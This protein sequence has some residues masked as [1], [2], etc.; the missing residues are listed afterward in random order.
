MC[1]SFCLHIYVC[2]PHECLEVKD[3]TG[4]S[5]IGVKHG[6]KLSG[7]CWELNLDPPEEEQCSSPTV[8]FVKLVS[9]LSFG[10][11]CSLVPHSPG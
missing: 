7:G 2:V 11:S 6:C 10:L 4:S 5:R 9:V 8:R 3:C 1:M